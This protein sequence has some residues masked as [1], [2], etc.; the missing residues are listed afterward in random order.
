M[1][2]LTVPVPVRFHFVLPCETKLL[3][4]FLT[5]ISVGGRGCFACMYVHLWPYL[6]WYNV[7]QVGEPMLQD[8]DG[9]VE[10]MSLPSPLNSLLCHDSNP[11][12]ESYWD[13]PRVYYLV[14]ILPRP[15][16]YLSPEDLG[17]TRIVS[18]PSVQCAADTP[19]DASTFLY[20]GINVLQ[21]NK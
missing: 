19:L 14:F 3:T 21:V 18:A 9:V 16:A 20:P 15:S 2:Y 6:R 11:I 17:C 8:V 1:A 10:F 5:G 12:S 4:R 7:C 13:T